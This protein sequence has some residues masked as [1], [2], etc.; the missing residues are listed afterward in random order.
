MRLPH[1]EGTRPQLGAGAIRS[2]TFTGP[3]TG[4][5]PLA[6]PE[7]RS[8]TFARS[9]GHPHVRATGLPNATGLLL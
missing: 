2:P 5:P 7:Y 3:P 8:G 9:S 6:T 1:R 4:G